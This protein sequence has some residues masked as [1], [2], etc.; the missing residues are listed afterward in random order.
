MRCQ[1]ALAAGQAH[2]R[3]EGATARRRQPRA[4]Q[5]ISTRC[6][7]VVGAALSHVLSAAQRVFWRAIEQGRGQRATASVS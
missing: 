7:R 3:K 6:R 2:H 4:S 1:K 5:V